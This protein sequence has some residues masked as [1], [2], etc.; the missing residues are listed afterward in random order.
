MNTNP[1]VS[2]ES[3]EEIGHTA[4]AIATTTSRASR[5]GIVKL[6]RGD[7]IRFKARSQLNTK[8]FFIDYIDDHMVRLI[9]DMRGKVAGGVG[10]DAHPHIIM[11]LDEHGRFEPDAQVEGIELLYRN[12]EPGYARQR[13]LVPG[14]W[15]EIEY[16]TEADD[17]KMIVYGEIKTLEHGTD[18]IGV[19]IYKGDGSGLGE[20]ELDENVAERPFVF[21]DFEFKGLSDELRIN[22]IRR[23]A[24]PKSLRDLSRGRSSS[25]AKKKSGVG[26]EE[27][28]EEEEEK[29]EQENAAS[30]AGEEEEGN[31]GSAKNLDFYKSPPAMDDGSVAQDESIVAGDKVVVVFEPFGAEEPIR[32]GVMVSQYYD[33][34][35]QRE[36]LRDKLLEIDGSTTLSSE[37]RRLRMIERYTQLR[38]IYSTE[39]D[40]RKHRTDYYTDEYKPLAELLFTYRDREREDK[41]DKPAT[42]VIGDWLIP[43]YVQRRI[44]HTNNAAEHITFSGMSGVVPKL[45]SNTLVSEIDNYKRYYSGEMSYREYKNA[46][47]QNTTPFMFLSDIRI[48]SFFNASQ[49][50]FEAVVTSPN[51][52]EHLLIPSINKLFIT[53]SKQEA[54]VMSTTRYLPGDD[55]PL[56]PTGYIT[57]SLSYAMLAAMKHSHA[58]ILDRVNSCQLVATDD[59]CWLN[60]DTPDELH[61]IGG[62]EPERGAII[63]TSVSE[64]RAHNAFAKPNSMKLCMFTARGVNGSVFDKSVILNMVPYTDELVDKLTLE[65]KK[66]QLSLSPRILIAYMKSFAIES[67]H[68]TEHLVS[69]F[70]KYIKEQIL[71]FRLIHRILKKKYQAFENFSYKTLPPALNALYDMM[72]SDADKMAK[73][74]LKDKNK[75]GAELKSI[76]DSTV[77]AN[78]KFKEW[79]VNSTVLPSSSSASSASASSTSTSLEHRKS[80][81][82]LSTSEFL[83]KIMGIDYGRSFITAIIAMNYS[84]DGMLFGTNV[85]KVLSHFIDDAKKFTLANE[86]DK[87]LRSENENGNEPDKRKAKYTLAKRYDS[88]DKMEEDNEHPPVYYDHLLDTTDYDFI[89]KFQTKRQSTDDESFKAFL[90]DKLAAL[91]KNAKVS[92]IKLKVEAESMMA[93]HRRVQEGDRAV[94]AIVRKKPTIQE[95]AADLEASSAGEREDDEDETV[96][97]YYKF[98]LIKGLDDGGISGGNGKWEHDAS[99]PDTVNPD[100]VTYFVNVTPGAIV[101]KSKILSADTRTSASS[102]KVMDS[103]AKAELIT[104]IHTEYD[105]AFEFEREKLQEMVSM[106][107]EYCDY[108]LHANILLQRK[109][110]V[111]LNNRDFMIGVTGNT[112]ALAA[113]TG[114]A[115]EMVISP[116]REILDSYLGVGSFPRKQ[117]L[118]LSFARTYTRE[119]NPSG[120]IESP[121]WLYCRDSGA[122]LMPVWMKQK[123]NAFIN[124][125]TGELSYISVLDRI[126]REYGIIEGDAWVDGKLCKSG[127]VIM[128]VAFSN[129]EGYDESGFKISTH[130]VMNDDS[131]MGGVDNDASME[132]E[133]EISESIIKQ[134]ADPK[135]RKISDVVTPVLK[136][137][138]GLPPDRDGLRSRI[139]AGVLQT[140]GEVVPP[141]L[142]SKEAYRSAVAAENAKKAPSYEKYCDSLILMIALAHVVVMLQCAMQE[143]RPAKHFRNCKTTFRGFPLDGDGS[144]ECIQYIACVAVGVRDSSKPVWTSVSSRDTEFFIKKIKEYITKIISNSDDT[145][146]K[147]LIDVKRRNNMKDAIVRLPKELS[148]KKWTQFFPLLHSLKGVNAP[149]GITEEVMK[150]FSKELKTGGES[151][152]DTIALIQSKIMKYSLFI[153]KMIQD[154]IQGNGKGA[155]IK[156]LL[157]FSTDHQPVVENACC[158]EM[159]LE[160]MNSSGKKGPAI[161][162]VLDYFVSNA[163]ANISEYNSQVRNLGNNLTDVEHI[164]RAPFLCS[165]ENTRLEM[166]GII[167][168]AY[169]ED[170]IFKGF[171]AFCKLDDEKPLLDKNVEKLRGKRPAD[172]NAGD[173]W[174]EKFKKLKTGGMEYNA[175]KFVELIDA[176]NVKSKLPSPKTMEVSDMSDAITKPFRNFIML[177]KKKPD[178]EELGM[179]LQSAESVFET[180]S[181]SS[182][183]SSSGSGS[184]SSVIFYSE[185]RQS[186]L[187]IINSGDASGSDK[188]CLRM[189]DVETV[190][191]ST[192]IQNFVNPTQ[193]SS[194]SE[195]ISKLKGIRVMSSRLDESYASAVAAS[196][197][198]KKTLRYSDESDA[199]TLKFVQFV[200]NGLRF[201][202][203]TVPGLLLSAESEKVIVPKHWKFSESHENDVSK[204]ISDQYTDLDKFCNKDD[205]KWCMRGL[206]AGGK[207]ATPG[208]DIM[209]FANSI[210]FTA[211][212]RSPLRTAIIKELFVYLFYSAVN[213]YVKNPPMQLGSGIGSGRSA[214][215]KFVKGG[216]GGG[217]SGGSA[218]ALDPSNLRSQTGYTAGEFRGEY[219]RSSVIDEI[220][221][222]R[223]LLMVVLKHVFN[224]KQDAMKPVG[225]MR[226]I[227]ASIRRRETEEMR[228]EFYL[229][230]NNE[231]DHAFMIK[232]EML[233]LRLGEYSVG[234]KAGYRTYNREFDEQERDARNKRL[235]EGKGNPEVSFE[236]AEADAADKG[237]S[238]QSLDGQDAIG[239]LDGDEFDRDQEARNELEIL[240][241]C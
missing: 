18:C 193:S 239:R 155:S 153:Q 82:I 95:E 32:F 156:Q 117:E 36:N 159:S 203:C 55:V 194:M 204:C 30:S 120:D 108:R 89:D 240:S 130:A 195:I 223:A 2:E 29:E 161:K 13:G 123:A 201:M 232:S 100:D 8:I 147:T 114:S 53:Q 40:G 231:N 11:N 20:P 199:S 113:M 218:S 169:S 77:A 126:C 60:R 87:C 21:I 38:E 119:A 78:Y 4:A 207:D 182:S 125:G 129:I 54:S 61:K 48:N 173:E 154:W 33:L 115:A 217:V 229:M 206:D 163:N 66:Y 149:E 39:R 5:R 122:K 23:C 151:Q 58:S 177:L 216:G 172:Y 64:M 227:M 189:L 124:D 83:G 165:V 107:T 174:G 187:S 197:D 179:E 31:E 86:T 118:I 28:E 184:A 158:D 34:D 224:M 92:P 57:R 76:F 10:A 140:L 211:N 19:S 221:H 234:A 80:R 75:M 65:L 110:Q 109:Q 141:L 71:A 70:G 181:G 46:I 164:G 132:I 178:I 73:V 79:M 145:L 139:I 97:N 42:E 143:V 7:V 198:D 16:I 134:F 72:L 102:G 112:A 166:A 235:A 131:D 127:M 213:L 3:D 192:R 220:D 96:Y 148:V 190:A 59:R 74:K 135:A 43:I 208:H 103:M 94:I 45:I 15:I 219:N 186:L 41:V 56:L 93:R 233:K 99:I 191:L 106:K 171:T 22:E 142:P 144:D 116:H 214:K 26:S 183:G 205:I 238:D 196:A 51:D 137:G 212:G 104:K 241:N 25:D 222:R 50:A 49:Y 215:S 68:I 202:L 176:V 111:A 47:A 146:L 27:E 88:M 6:M 85:G 168:T 167:S 133:A 236:V 37:K 101:M 226:E 170:T 136:N 237:R 17:G 138:V 180:G 81:R 24:M 210:P 228:H 1:S 105:T 160:E 9:P 98:V 121:H 12:D 175:E 14:T 91:P 157:L 35:Q 69:K 209:Q 162:S 185:L 90:M 62:S 128:S 230:S 84:H 225:V 67:H 63:D 188:E 44:I 150:R 52:P 152:H 200:K